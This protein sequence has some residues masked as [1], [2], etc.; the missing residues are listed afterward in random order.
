[1]SKKTYFISDLHLGVGARVSSAER[2][3]EVVRFLDKIASNADAIYFVGDIFEF[4]FEYST[5]IP[6]G[7]SRFFG[8]IAELSD[9]GIP[10]YL[11]TGNHDMWIFD[12]FEKEFNI[13]TYR[14][15][16]VRELY[17]KQF[18]IGHGDG[19]GPGDHGYKFLKKVFANPIC[20][21]LFERIHPN[22]GIKLANFWSGKSRDLKYLK[23]KDWLGAENEWLV[24]F[25]EEKLSEQPEID[26]FLF[27]HRHLPIDHTLS[28]RKSRYINT[29]DWLN[30]NSYAAFDGEKM[31][32]GFFETEPVFFKY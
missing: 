17:G 5:V 25:C 15:P 32:I 1:M 30:Y 22:F 16:I 12:Y 2:E 3:R 18:L 20:Q 6:K 28:N 14:Q 13:P 31:E 11:F 21:W 19:L 23:R 24:S 29:G 7:Y 9:A 10:M 4:W 27:G 8:K 26:F